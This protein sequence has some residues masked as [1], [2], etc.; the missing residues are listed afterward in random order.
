MKMI[1]SIKTPDHQP[2]QQQAQH[3]CEDD[4]KRQGYPQIAG[5]LRQRERE[6]GADHVEASVREIDHAYDAEDQRETARD[7]EQEQPVLNA[8][9]D[10]NQPFHGGNLS[11]TTSTDACK[12]EAGHAPRPDGF[13]Y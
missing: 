1:A 12:K 9:E 3:R 4:A 13:E 6:V 8:I 2:L 7:Q 11:A 5:P 10:L